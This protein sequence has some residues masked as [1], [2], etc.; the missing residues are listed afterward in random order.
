MTFK[1]LIAM[2]F[3]SLIPTLS[4]AQEKTYQ[5][6]HYHQKHAKG[7][8]RHH[9]EMRAMYR[10]SFKQMSHLLIPKAIDLSPQVSLPQDQGTCGCCWDFSLTKALRSEYML[11]KHDPGVLEFNFLLNNCGKGPQM[12]GCNGGDFT[13]AA[14]FLNNEGP[15]LNSADP[16]TA[17]QGTCKGLPV[18]GTAA[19]YTMLG[20]GDSGPTFQELAYAVGIER[21]MV[22]IDVAAGIGDWENYSGG[23]YNDCQGGV[24]DIDHM[25]DLVGYDCETSTDSDGHCIFDLNGHPIHHDGYLLIENNWGES[26]GVKA[27]NGHRG[28]MKTRMYGSDGSNC[29]A[30]ATDALIFTIK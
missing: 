25:I 21:H 4:L 3:I 22:S 18:K 29:N 1:S 10:T 8:K 6:K 16:F 23:I 12:E 7:M 14:S 19:T 11:A 17:R 24:N 9:E 30:V 13:A 26:W 2:A 20:D 28:Y 5:V 15:G 27:A